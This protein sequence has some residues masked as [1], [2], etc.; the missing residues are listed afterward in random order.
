VILTEEE[1][2]TKWCPFVRLISAVPE[3]APLD[4]R[5]AFVTDSAPRCI[6]SACMA[7]RVH[8][9]WRADTLKTTVKGFC[10]LAASS[11]PSPVPAS[12]MDG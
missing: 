9:E 2:K 4:N 8:E 11:S 5:G 12:L 7:W 6:G 3:S 10:G 1:A